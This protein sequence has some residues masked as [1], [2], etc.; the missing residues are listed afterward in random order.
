MQRLCFGLEDHNNKKKDIHQLEAFQ[1][2]C[3]KQLQGLPTRSSDT[4]SLALVGWLPVNV[5]VEKKALSLFC[6]IS[7]DQTCIEN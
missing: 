5:C 6:S 1:K 2:R 4:A 3:L 7:R